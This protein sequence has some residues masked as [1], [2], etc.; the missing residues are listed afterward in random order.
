MILIDA[1]LLVYAVNRDLPPHPK[2][3]AWLEHVLSGSEGVGLPSIVLLAFLRLT[4]SRHIFERALTVQ[5]ATAYVDQWLSQP[6]VTVPAPGSSHWR[7]LRN[8]LLQTGS[9]GNLTTDAHLAALAL[10]HGYTVC[11]C[12]HDFKR[13]PGLKHIDPLVA[14]SKP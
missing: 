3:R 9:G 7:I 8:L 13:F 4:T 2:A 5:D 1:N 12:D 11:S 14:P 6:V 10:E